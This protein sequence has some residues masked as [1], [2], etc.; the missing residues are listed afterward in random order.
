MR[1]VES[2]G[3]RQLAVV[4]DLDAAPY[5]IDPSVSAVTRPMAAS[6]RDGGSDQPFERAI[7]AAA[8]IV[9][10][11]ASQGRDVRFL[12]TAG[13]EI[14]PSAGN[15][16]DVLEYL[17]LATTAV[18]TPVEATVGA[19]GS[20][21]TGGLLVYV[22]GR[23]DS[24]RLT[25]LA[26]R[27]RRGCCGGGRLPG[28][29][30]HPDR[31]RL[32]RRRDDRRALHRLV[33]APR[34]R[35]PGRRARRADA[36]LGH[37]GGRA[38]TATLARQNGQGAAPNDPSSEEQHVAEQP[39]GDDEHQ[40]GRRRVSQLEPITPLN[41]VATFALAATTV[42]AAATLWRVFP[43]WGFLP[44]VVITALGVHA[45]TLACRWRRFGLVVSTL[46]CL[47]ALAIIITV[48]YFR[49]HRL[50][51]PPHPPRPGTRPGA[52]SP[53]RGP[54]SARRS[55]PCRPAAATG[56]PPPPPWG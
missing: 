46:A 40:P 15:V 49:R 55:R 50:R 31:R 10:S 23:I 44:P 20:K 7:T 19:L 51:V 14:R 34:R 9:M 6:L 8:S 37:H 5:G 47:A 4:L 17:A 2:E 21:M 28:A 12:S 26:R 53:T 54:S 56:S 22:S 18:R 45:V 1:E 29:A 16:D 43:D 38:V 27:R 11:A 3:L 48:V 35:H 24:G 39:D 41:L 30:A 32:R 25:S 36:R 42:A 52:T 33:D 13:F